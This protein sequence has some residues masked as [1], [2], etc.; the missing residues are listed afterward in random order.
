MQKELLQQRIQAHIL[1]KSSI[2]KDKYCKLLNPSAHNIKNKKQVWLIKTNPWKIEWVSN[3]S[4][5]EI[6]QNKGLLNS[7][8]EK[9]NKTGHTE[10]KTKGRKKCNK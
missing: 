9:Q 7:L 8:N 3:Y 10:P 6:P 1:S 4:K 5:I 2:Q